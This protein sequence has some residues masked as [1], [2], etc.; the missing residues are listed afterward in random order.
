[1]K[2]NSKKLSGGATFFERS[3]DWYLSTSWWPRPRAVG[4]Q[5]GRGRNG[6]AAATVRWSWWPWAVGLAVA[7]TSADGR[8]PSLFSSTGRRTGRGSSFSTATSPTRFGPAGRKGI[9]F[10]PEVRKG[11]LFDPRVKT[12]KSGRKLMTGKGSLWTLR[13]KIVISYR[14][15]KTEM[16]FVPRATPEVQNTSRFMV[17]CTNVT[18]YSDGFIMTRACKRWNL[19]GRSWPEKG[20]YEPW[21]IK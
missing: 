6:P 19:A 12:V 3:Y 10:V 4:R 7:S 16:F 21:G 9:F 8:G 17:E 11:F 15:H 18:F 1:M 20:L 14:D 13:D 2:E 5:S